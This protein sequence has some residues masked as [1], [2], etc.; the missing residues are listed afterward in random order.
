MP[1]LFSGSELSSSGAGSVSRKSRFCLVSVP[2]YR[3]LMWA[4]LIIPQW[5]KPS[6]TGFK[7]V[8]KGIDIFSGSLCFIYLSMAL[9]LKGSVFLCFVYLSITLLLIDKCI[10][11]ASEEHSL[12]DSE[13]F[14]GI[15][16]N[17]NFE[18]FL[19]SVLFLLCIR[20]SIT[21]LLISNCIRGLFEDHV[22]KGLGGFCPVFPVCPV[23]SHNNYYDSFLFLVLFRYGINKPIQRNI[24]KVHQVY[25]QPEQKQNQSLIIWLDFRASLP[26]FPA[27]RLL[28]R[29]IENLSQMPLKCL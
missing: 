2:L 15:R 18:G 20:L 1:V 23:S 24:S 4:L 22:L 7:T 14:S 9:F 16:I 6:H 28:V 3:G 11:R 19:W 29:T 21:L 17:S 5:T 12:F 8:L 10:R 26:C 27:L 25:F 13:P